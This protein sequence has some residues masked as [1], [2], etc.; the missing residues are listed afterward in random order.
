MKLPILP[1]IDRHPVKRVNSATEVIYH[2][3]EDKAGED[4]CQVNTISVQ[5][6]RKQVSGFMGAT[7]V[8]S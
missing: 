4:Q 8:P 2:V 7:T 3:H 5:F 6:S 1:A